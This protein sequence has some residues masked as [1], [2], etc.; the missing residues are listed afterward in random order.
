MKDVDGKVAFITGGASG[1][2][3]GMAK[4]FSENG[5]KVVIADIRQEALD[6][7]MGFFR[8]TNRPVHPDQARRDG[9]QVVGRGSR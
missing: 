5:M 4:V 9:S 6:E 1:M 2:G 8:Q 7:A 3:L